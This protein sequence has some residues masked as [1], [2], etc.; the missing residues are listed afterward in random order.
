M[1]ELRRGQIKV[2][3]AF[4]KHL[5]AMESFESIEDERIQTMIVDWLK[6]R[7]SMKEHLLTDIKRKQLLKHSMAFQLDCIITPNDFHF[8]HTC[9]TYD[10]YIE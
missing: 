6:T 4:S 7:D 10:T 5:S 2:L 8:G 3:K 9:H 1:V